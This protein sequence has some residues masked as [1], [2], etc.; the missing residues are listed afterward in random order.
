[1]SQFSYIAAQSG[2]SEVKG[3]VEASSEREAVQQLRGQGLFVISIDEGGG[4]STSASGWLKPL[5][6]SQWL[7]VKKSAYIQL[8]RQLSLMLMSGHT[9]IESLELSSTLAPRRRLAKTLDEL[10]DG[11]QQGMS[12]AQAMEEHPK[13]F[14]PNVVE[15]VRSAES[16]GEMDTVLLRLANDM[17][18]MQE[19]RSQLITSLIYPA[20]VLLMTI[21]LLLMMA[22][23]VLPKLKTFI[24]SKASDLPSSTANMIAM[25]DF[26]V[27][28]GAKL[29]SGVLVI[30]FLLLASYTTVSGKRFFDRFF[31]SVPLVGKSIISSS[32]AQ[33]GWT[34]SMLSASGITIM[35]SLKICSRVTGNET[36]KSSLHRASEDVLQG[37]TLSNALNQPAIPDL[38]YKMAAVGEQSGEFD[39]VMNEIGGYYS[40]ELQASLKR[41]LAFI[42]PALLLLV[43][44]PVAFVYLSIFQLIFA[45]STGGR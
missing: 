8:Y 26:I 40:A 12:F 7:P 11:I 37:N 27:N 33:I 45:V 23:W 21:G 10:R 16:S 44:I 14:K 34:L 43:G 28:H 18:R 22:V 25:S 1:M 32:M 3:V 42:E 13:A 20:I 30:I 41:M 38:F 29:G 36:L 35:D 31:L 5:S 15:L 6:L 19:M 4:A 2:K 9:L 24:E 39:R 17:E